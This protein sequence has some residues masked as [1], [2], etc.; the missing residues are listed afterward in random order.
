MKSNRYISIRRLVFICM[1]IVPALPFAVTL[2]IGHYYF[3]TSLENGAV[4]TIERIVSDH[5]RIIDTF[6]SERKSDLDFVINATHLEDLKR[7]ENLERIFDLLK[8]KSS[9]FIDLGVFD[10]SGLH[11]SYQGPYALTG[12]N[13][14]DADWFREVMAKGTYVSDV[15][16]GVRQVP[17]FVIAVMREEGGSNWVLRATIDTELFS[18]LVESV[19]IGETSDT[20][21][22]N[23]DGSYQTVSH[24]AVDLM[25]KDP[26][27]ETFPGA[28]NQVNTFIRT[29]PSGRT[30]LYAVTRLTE[31]DW[32]LVTRMDKAAAL[33]SL[34]AAARRILLT[35]IV[36]GLF[37]VLA[38][39]GL[40]RYILGRIMELDREKDTLSQQL[41]RAS[42]LAEL[43]EMSAGFAHEVNNPLQIMKSEL[44]LIQILWND[45]SKDTLQAPHED[46]SQIEDCLDQLQLQVDRCGNITQGILQFARHSSP[47]PQGIDLR[48]FIPQVVSMVA[49]QANVNGI[50]LAQKISGPTLPVHGDPGQLQQVLLNLLNN[51]MDATLERHGTQGGCVE[52]EAAVS[53]SEGEF[54]TLSVKDNGLGIS[55][56][57]RKK[58]FSPFFTTKP[59]GK[60]TGLGLSVCHGIVEGMGGRMEFTSEHGVGSV[61][62]IHLPAGG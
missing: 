62:S 3:S 18:D 6:L 9:A 58:I 19:R 29:D 43:G 40:T 11:L 4:S 22:L 42:R 17:H 39:L 15:F 20:Y 54:I 56:E 31:K 55:D 44:G 32:R 28:G 36:G 47:N 57:N 53:N 35:A 21:L 16:L 37:I 33:G 25:Q 8:K 23:A 45:I 59:V 46:I 13:Y 48:S 60:G 41:I 30:Y 2:M 38:A 5:G 34:R 49:K 52:I 27:V 26:E 50:A 7:P 10:A 14:Q 12:I 24:G 61:F 51:A 1:V